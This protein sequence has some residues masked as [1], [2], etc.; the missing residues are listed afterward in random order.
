MRK[1]LM[2]RGKQPRLQYKVL[3]FKLNPN[4]KINIL[5]QVGLEAANF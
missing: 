5:G 2:S 1:G 3:K 4:I